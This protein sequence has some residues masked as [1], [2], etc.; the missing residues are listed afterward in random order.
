MLIKIVYLFVYE[1]IVYYPKSRKNDGVLGFVH[2]WLE[3]LADEFESIVVVCLGVGTYN[4][5]GNVSVIF[6]WQRE[7]WI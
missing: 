3:K 6:A 7:S 5:P 2:G 4:L 1:I